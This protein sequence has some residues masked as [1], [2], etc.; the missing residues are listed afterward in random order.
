MRAVMMPQI[1]EIKIL[2]QMHRPGVQQL[3][4]PLFLLTS[5]EHTGGLQARDPIPQLKKAI[6][7]GNILTQD[8]L[9]QIEKDVLAEV[10]ASVQFAEESPKPVSAE[11]STSCTAF[12][13]AFAS[14]HTVLDAFSCTWNITQAAAQGLA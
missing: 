11:T 14:L 3:C 6:L 4:R 12:H 7:E 2:Q 10:D 1:S 8:E 9:K 13:L 5:S